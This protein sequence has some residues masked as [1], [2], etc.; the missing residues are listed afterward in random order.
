[1]VLGNKWP[2]EKIPSGSQSDHVIDF[3]EQH[4]KKLLTTHIA[5]LESRYML[6]FQPVRRFIQVFHI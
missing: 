6:H 1:M 3:Y 5:I 4:L 2:T